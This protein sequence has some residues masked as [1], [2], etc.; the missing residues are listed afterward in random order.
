MLVSTGVPEKTVD[1]RLTPEEL[2]LDYPVALHNQWSH[3]LGWVFF[4][5]TET[6]INFFINIVQR[7]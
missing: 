3:R 6:I 1:D 7:L 4:L 2:F 5:C